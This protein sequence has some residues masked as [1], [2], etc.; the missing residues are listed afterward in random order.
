M[1]SFRQL[2][3]MSGLLASISTAAAAS[4][5]H[6]H[7]GSKSQTLKI[8]S[9]KRPIDECLFSIQAYP[10][11]DE[12]EFGMFHL[13]HT[14]DHEMVLV[15]YITSTFFWFGNN[16][17]VTDSQPDMPYY[18]LGIDRHQD[19]LGRAVEMG[20]YESTRF[21]L[22]DFH[23]GQHRADSSIGDLVP[24]DLTFS[25]DWKACET[26]FGRIQV[27][28]SDSVTVEQH[29]TLIRL[30]AS[31]RGKCN[32]PTEPL[33]ATKFSAAGSILRQPITWTIALTGYIIA[34]S[35]LF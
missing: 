25:Y 12:P 23:E 11:D 27:F 28:L 31:F 29:C 33:R 24:K 35:Y 15:P 22:K 19:R 1:A 34:F 16:N 3:L 4:A 20:T 32:R 5:R 17:S 2:I 13:T 21:D 26:D 18:T 9:L 14:D 10:R 7:S 30:V 6:S 8:D